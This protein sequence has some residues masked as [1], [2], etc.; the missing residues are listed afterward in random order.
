MTT[1][2]T[3]P[4]AN[5]R[6]GVHARWTRARPWVSTVA[7]VLLGAVWI[8]AGASK[9]TDLAASVR[10]VR[11]YEVLPEWAVPAVG[12]GLPFLEVAL[13]VLLIVG[14]GV[15]LGAVVSAVL[16][17]IF[18][19]GI[20]SASARGLR[21]DCGCFG[22]GGE[23][24]AGQQTKYTAEIVRDVGL[25]GLAALVAWLPRGRFSVDGWISGPNR[26]AHDH[27]HEGDE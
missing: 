5:Q 22:G 20:V 27:T 23:L 18:I 16:F 11:A 2:S 4:A 19:A 3:A 14:L 24:G 1:E 8:A 17:A 12:A 9:V 6:A 7:R 25:L 13:G 15:R 21:I 26:L 10:A